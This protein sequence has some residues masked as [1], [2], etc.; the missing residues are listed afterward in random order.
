MKVRKNTKQK[1]TKAYTHAGSKER[2]TTYKP[3]KND[4]VVT[5]ARGDFNEYDDEGDDK[6]FDKL[7]YIPYRN[8]MYESE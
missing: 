7:K 2:K 6:Y 4:G 5:Y 8:R 1:K 3:I